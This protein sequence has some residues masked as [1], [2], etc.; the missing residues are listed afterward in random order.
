MKRV[1]TPEEYL[2]RLDERVNRIV[3]RALERMLEALGGPQRLTPRQR[4]ERREL[5]V[6]EGGKKA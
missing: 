2:A 5:R 6:I 3:D 4:A 1:R